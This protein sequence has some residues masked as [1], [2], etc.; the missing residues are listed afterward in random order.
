M[1]VARID[2]NGR[3]TYSSASS[4]SNILNYVG[5]KNKYKAAVIVINSGGGDATS[6]QLIYESVRKLDNKKPVYALIIG[7]GASGAYWASVG[8]RRIYAM[9]T[10]MVGSI[11][12]ISINPKVAGLMEKLGVS[13]KVTKVGKYKDYMSP[14]SSGDEGMENFQELLNDVYDIFLKEVVSRRKIPDSAVD[15]IGTGEVFSAKKAREL[16]LID[17][18]GNFEDTINDLRSRYEISGKLKN[19]S[20]RRSLISRFIGLTVNEI[21]ESI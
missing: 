15:S 11:G 3:I 14:F 20:P 12:V 16:N 7:M 17:A 19:L 10:S 9:S 6:S 1:S 21:L 5:A 2:L 18:I 4:I 13:I 8:A